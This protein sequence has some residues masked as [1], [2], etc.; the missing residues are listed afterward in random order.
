MSLEASNQLDEVQVEGE[1]MAG[2]VNEDGL[3]EVDLGGRE[4]HATSDGEVEANDKDRE[5][6]VVHQQT[7]PE[8][9]NDVEKAGVKSE[10]GHE[11]SV[12]EPAEAP[13]LPIL[14]GV[15]L[16]YAFAFN[17]VSPEEVISLSITSTR[18]LAVN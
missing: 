11:L 2:V 4:G 6:S 7:P 14:N 16:A 9:E 3:E 12:T 13:P 15:K 17:T 5:G 8:E 1:V 10:T 18:V